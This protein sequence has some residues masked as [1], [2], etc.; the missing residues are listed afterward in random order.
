MA[1]TTSAPPAPLQD[2]IE[3]IWDWRVEPG[4]FRFERILPQPGAALVINLLEDETRV[5]DDDAHRR[6]ECSPGAVFSG[7]F[8]RSFLIDT[9]E[10]V[11]VMGV[12]FRPG[13]ANAFVRERMDLVRRSPYRARRHRRRRQSRA[14]TT[15]AAYA[16]RACAHP[17]GRVVVAQPLARNIPASGRRGHP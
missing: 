8:T 15:P 9:A 16:A 5:Y 17:R 14:E 13:G 10:Q 1:F 6:C 3:T 4:E 2:H 12:V 11:A 7:Q